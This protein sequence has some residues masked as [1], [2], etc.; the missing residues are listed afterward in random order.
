MDQT[1]TLK[2]SEL[3]LSK[4]IVLFLPLLQMHFLNNHKIVAK[5]R[6]HFKNKIRAFGVRPVLINIACILFC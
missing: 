6:S 4:V 2:R 1:M 5:S 3:L